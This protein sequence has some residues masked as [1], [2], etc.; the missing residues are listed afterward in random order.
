LSGEPV[1]C[2]VLDFEEGEK[3]GK[4]EAITHTSKVVGNFLAKLSAQH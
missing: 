4:K 2:L 3:E 1:S